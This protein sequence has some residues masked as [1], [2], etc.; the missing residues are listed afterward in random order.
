LKKLHPSEKL[1]FSI[2]LLLDKETYPTLILLSL[3]HPQISDASTSKIFMRMCC[4]VDY[5]IVHS[6]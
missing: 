5:E 2:T 4:G 1:T 6:T 3:P